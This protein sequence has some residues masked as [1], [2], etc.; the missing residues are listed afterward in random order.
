LNKQD[1]NTLLK[2]QQDEE[3]VMHGEFIRGQQVQVQQLEQTI[4]RLQS[5]IDNYYGI[6]PL[7]E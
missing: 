1:I 5:K 4:Q 2:N 3:D 6:F 7:Q